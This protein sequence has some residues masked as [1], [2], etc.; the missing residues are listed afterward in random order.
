MWI[1]KIIYWINSMSK[2]KKTCQNLDSDRF[3]LVII[4]YKFN[5]NLI[6]VSL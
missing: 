4:I 3:L 6:P 2:Y 1:M 5:F